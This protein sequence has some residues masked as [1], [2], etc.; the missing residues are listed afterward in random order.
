MS[1]DQGQS[2]TSWL[3]QGVASA[4]V[5][6]TA[7]LLVTRAYQTWNNY[8]EFL[9]DGP[10]LGKRLERLLSDLDGLQFVLLD[11]PFNNSMGI[12]ELARLEMT[13][14]RL[15]ENA[16]KTSKTLRVFTDEPE[17]MP[18]NVLANR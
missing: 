9:A 12:S 6:G 8:C 17:R 7:R 4:A 11:V 5:Y 1:L 3:A 10:N 18:H 14:A 2:N 16:Q 13:L 15:E